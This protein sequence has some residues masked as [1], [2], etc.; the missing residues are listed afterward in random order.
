MRFSRLARRPKVID[1]VGRR[2]PLT[3]AAR[4]GIGQ[5]KYFGGA[6]FFTEYSM[7]AVELA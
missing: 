2:H 4:P 6:M 3:S 7:S 1:G 5:E